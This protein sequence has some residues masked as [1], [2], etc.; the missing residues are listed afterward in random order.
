MFM[1]QQPAMPSLGS[2]GIIVPRTVCFPTAGVQE[3]SYRPSTLG[4]SKHLSTLCASAGK[5]HASGKCSAGIELRLYRGQI[6]NVYLCKMQNT[7][8]D[9]Q[10]ATCQRQDTRSKSQDKICKLH[11]RKAHRMTQPLSM[12]DQQR[13][14]QAAQPSSYSR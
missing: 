4:L 3:A 7:I 10:P 14:W 6:Y 9:M 1:H 5:R 8:C 13:N 11:P 2:S 12:A